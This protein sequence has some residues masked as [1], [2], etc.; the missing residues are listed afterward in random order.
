MGLERG[1]T[2]GSG[3][4]GGV[5]GSAWPDRAGWA[6]LWNCTIW[7]D[8]LLTRAIKRITVAGERKES[9]SKKNEPLPL[10]FSDYEISAGCCCGR[11]R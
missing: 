6:M 2:A 10:H 4:V 7:T 11:V 3:R 1:R 5:M 9:I 8:G